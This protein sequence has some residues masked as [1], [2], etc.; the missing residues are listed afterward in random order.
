[1]NEQAV[2][3]FLQAV[4]ERRFDD[5]EQLLTPGVV[6]RWITPGGMDEQSGADT[7]VDRYR[8]WFGGLKR[9]DVLST[10]C[11]AMGGR[12]MFSYQLRVCKPDG[13]WRMVQQQGVLDAS[14]AGVVAV[15]LVCT[16][17]LAT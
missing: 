13:T 14:D 2:Q 17:F 15:D 11:E 1:M 9:V 6:L 16:G 10:H 12:F 5:L 8:S 4:C 7:V 3:Q